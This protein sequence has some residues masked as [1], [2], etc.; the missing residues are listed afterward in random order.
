V[1]H[2]GGLVET[3]YQYGFAVIALALLAFAALMQRSREQDPV[4]PA[5]RSDEVSTAARELCSAQAAS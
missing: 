3:A 1:V 2:G 4:V 5:P